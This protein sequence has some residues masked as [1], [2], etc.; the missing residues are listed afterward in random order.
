MNFLTKRVIS[1]PKGR[2]TLVARQKHHN[3]RQSD[4]RKDSGARSR[5]VSV[6]GQ[7]RG[8]N[9]R[10][11]CR[12][13][14]AECSAESAVQFKRQQQQRCRHLDLDTWIR[15]A[16]DGVLSLVTYL[17]ATGEQ[18]VT[19]ER[20]ISFVG[21]RFSRDRSKIKYRALSVCRYRPTDTSEWRTMKIL[22]RKI[23]EATVNNLYPGREYEFMV[24]SQDK[25]GD[26]M[27][28]KALRIFTQPSRSITRRPCV[29][30][31]LNVSCGVNGDCTF[32]F[33]QR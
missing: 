18:I 8:S 5:I 7:Q 32:R 15:E 10:R 21:D 33:H 11:G 24:L 26:G 6:R 20:T 25:N 17:F 9:G 29:V 19:T 22:S 14:G 30:A 4:D 28:S 13:N 3:R 23:T 1:L 27:F 2:N 31:C 16:E 12:I